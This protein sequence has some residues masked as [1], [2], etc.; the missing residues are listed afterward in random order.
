MKAE[1]AEELCQLDNRNNNTVLATTSSMTSVRAERSGK[2]MKVEAATV[3]RLAQTLGAGRSHPEDQLDLSGGVELRVEPGDCVKE[4][5]VW[6]V[7]HHNRDIPPHLLQGNVA[8][9]SF[10]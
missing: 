3:A 4:G 7:I 2:V 9:I 6:A 1:V 8:S 5:E 10:S